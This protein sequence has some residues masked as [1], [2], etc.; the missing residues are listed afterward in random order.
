MYLIAGLG[1]PGDKYDGTRH[2]MG[3]DVVTELIDRHRIPSSGIAMKALYGKGLLGGQKAMLMKPLTYM[4][5]SGEAVQ[6]FVHYY[7]IDPAEELIVIYDDIDL[8]PGQIRIRQKGSAGSHNGMKSVISCLGTNSFTRVRV[9]VGAK[10]EGWDLAD[11]VLSRPGKEERAL[12]NEA[13]AHAADAIE[14]IVSGETEKA[15][16]LYNGRGSV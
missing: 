5:L 9:G 4:N 8:E 1:N 10:P 3:F 2:N 7:K 14:L 11:Y 15:M 13:I 6:Q 16:S 12:I